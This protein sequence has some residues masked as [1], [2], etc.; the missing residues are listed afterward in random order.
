MRKKKQKIKIQVHDLRKWA[1]GKHKTADDKPYGGGCGMVLKIE[2]IYR[3]IAHLVGKKAVK[4]ILDKA[5]IKKGTKIILLSPKGKNFNN[6]CA[7]SFSKLKHIIFVCGHY[8]GVD[9][10]VK[11]LVTEEISIGDYI[12]TGGEI[13]SM[14]IVDAMARFIPGVLGDKRSVECESF[15]NNLLEHPHYTRPREFEGMKVPEILLSGD[16]G[17]I[18]E[19]RD[20][21]SLKKTKNT[22][23]D[24]YK[25]FT[26]KS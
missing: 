5:Y 10:R 1:S 9:E 7:K 4:K 15:E 8:E 12:L 2:P 16:H 11:R 18:N 3:A 21:E 6:T 26:K 20:A 24:L 13:A 25:L 22:R 14:V 23:R 17:A 19:W